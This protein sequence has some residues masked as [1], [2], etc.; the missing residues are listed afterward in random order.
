MR[1]VILRPE[2][3]LDIEDIADYTIQQ[4]GKDQARKYVA[5]LRQMIERLS[6]NAERFPLSDLPF[7]GL[8]RMRCRHHLVYYLVDEAH[9]DVVRILHER[10]D[11]S[12]HLED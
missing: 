9:V 12:A 5:E 3:A 10:M 2:A 11:A 8:H 4:W 6:D 7:P 1:E